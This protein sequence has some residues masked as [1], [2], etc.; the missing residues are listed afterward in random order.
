MKKPTGQDRLNAQKAEQFNRYVWHTTRSFRWQDSMRA[1]VTSIC[2][3]SL[4]PEAS[5]SP[6]QADETDARTIT[7][8]FVITPEDVNSDKIMDEAGLSRLNDDLSTAA[9]LWFDDCDAIHP[10]VSTSMTAH[11]KRLP[12]VGTTID[13]ICSVLGYDG[14]LVYTHTEIV[15]VDPSASATIP[16]RPEILGTLNHTKFVAEKTTKSHL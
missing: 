9:I 3:P 11:L 2:A 7:Y 12:R 15:Q 6:G 4:N 16:R 1:T 10:G 13:L 8:R 14:P 5:A